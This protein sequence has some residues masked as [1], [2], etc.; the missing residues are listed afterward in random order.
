MKPRYAIINELER[1]Q[2]EKEYQIPYGYGNVD[3]FF[4]LEEALEEAENYTGDFG[5]VVEEISD[6]GRQVV[7]RI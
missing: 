3:V 2:F 5:F 7:I 1:D 6:G 4:D